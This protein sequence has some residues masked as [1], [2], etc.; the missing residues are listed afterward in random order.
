MSESPSLPAPAASLSHVL[1]QTRRGN[2]LEETIA[3]LLRGIRLGSFPPGDKLPPERELAESLG[4]SR[5]TL[6]DA[7]AALQHTGHLSVRRGRY[8]GT[9]VTEEPPG[10]AT[11]LHA[12][13]AADVEDVLTFRGVVEPAAASL[14]AAATLSTEQRSALVQALQAVDNAEP[15]QYRPLDA[16]LHCLIAELSG[17]AMLTASVVE[18][19]AAASALLDRIPFLDTNIAHSQEQHQAIVSAILQGEPTRAGELMQEHLEGTAS[20]LR[21]FLADEGPASGPQP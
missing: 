20:L 10:P 16:R 17:S 7:L 9:F 4:V 6:R 21:G 13:D 3:R 1:G 15:A 18:A 8:G 2:V 14:A 12:G 11:T 5:S 19:R